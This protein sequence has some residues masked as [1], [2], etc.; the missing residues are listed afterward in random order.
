MTDLPRGQCAEHGGRDLAA[1]DH[2]VTP[3]TNER[4]TE[5]LVIDPAHLGEFIAQVTRCATV[6]CR[7]TATEEVSYHYRG[8]DEKTTERVCTPCAD[9]YE[10]R[11]VLARFTR[12]DV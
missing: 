4:G 12:K 3:V 11:P 10:R 9:S 7:R 6:G 8:E 2:G 1:C 5:I